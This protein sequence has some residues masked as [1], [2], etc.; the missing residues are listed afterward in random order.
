MKAIAV[1]P[2][3]GGS[4]G[5]PG[6]NVK[7]LNG[8]P[9]IGR[10]VLAAAGAEYI[11]DVYVSSDSDEI[12]EVSTRYGAH[13]ILRPDDISGPTAS[14][15]SA[16]IHALRHV[17]E[18]DGAM[19][20]VIVFLQCTSPFTT[21]AH[22]DAIVGELIEQNAI[23]AFAATE[24]HGFIW[25]IAEDGSAVGIT[26][27]ET[28]PRQR[29]QDMTPR[30][31]ETGAV[32]AVRVPEFLKTQNRFCGR[33]ILVPVDM[34]P[35]EIDTPADWEIA[36]AFARLHDPLMTVPA[37]KI[38]AL[39]TDFDGVHTDDLVIV[40]QDGTESVRCSRSDG[41]GIEALKKRGLRL[42]ILSREQNPVVK[43]RANKLHMEVQHH[44]HNKLPAL[45]AW[46]IEHNLDWSEIAY[47]GN[48]LND[49]ECMRACGMS[50]APSDAHRDVLGIAGVKLT[51]QGGQ[52]ALRE[53]SEYMIANNL[54][55]Q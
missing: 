33:T 50:F 38:K 2:A 20:D 1:V 42:L 9:L 31:R 17:A 44:V 24:D 30:Y 48:D 36:E 49:L 39:V 46:R 35:V 41:M 10:A 32:Y 52:G 16:L 12:L 8:I 4:R 54:L 18:T 47:V 28:K 3:R 29:R 15:E 19:P 26:H 21:S 43:A 27:D 11:S 53:L 14:S 25:Q 45:D 13:A 51:K 34:P 55:A 7:P 40:H 5:L 6:K 23:S 37:Q 22:I